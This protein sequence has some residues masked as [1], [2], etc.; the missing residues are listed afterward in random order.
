MQTK[1]LI[2]ATEFCNYYNIEISFINSLCE[3][4]LIEI[5]IIEDE[6]YIRENQLVELEKILR[7]YF[8]MDINLEGIET[9]LYLLQ[10]INSMHNE[11][12][13]LKNRLQLYE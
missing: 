2:P 5:T 11:I 12:T 7:L 6:E 9:I 4:G 10:K 1:H 13:L 8:E 3:I